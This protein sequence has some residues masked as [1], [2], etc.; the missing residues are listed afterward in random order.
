MRT[1]PL[2]KSDRLRPFSSC[3]LFILED[4]EVV[5]IHGEHAVVILLE[6]LAVTAIKRTRGNAFATPEL[7]RRK[8]YALPLARDAAFFVAPMMEWADATS[9]L[10]SNPVGIA[11]S[12]LDTRIWRTSRLA[13]ELVRRAQQTGANQ[14]I[15][16]VVA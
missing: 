11:T 4:M 10:F 7:S 2:A 1:S 9:K 6:D 13:C 16:C 8:P 3:P 15:E 14:A 12:L 5:S